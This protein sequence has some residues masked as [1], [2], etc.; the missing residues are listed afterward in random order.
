[1]CALCHVDPA[2]LRGAFFKHTL[3]HSRA[4]PHG[5][6]SKP[7]SFMRLF[8]YLTR[9]RYI[10]ILGMKLLQTNF[11]CCLFSHVDFLP[12]SC[13]SFICLLLDKR[14]NF[15]FVTKG[16]QSEV[17][18]MFVQLSAPVAF[19][20]IKHESLLLHKLMGYFSSEVF[21]CSVARQSEIPQMFPPC[22]SRG[23]VSL[24]SRKQTPVSL[25][26]QP[27]VLLGQ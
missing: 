21:N 9:A 12:F 17:S 15:L 10:S 3:Q 24:T 8:W 14:C 20:D 22:Q 4:V 16:L 18:L 1:M 27:N 6:P 2:I 26:K 11:P 7:F 25:K 5:C 13:V 19:W 23:E